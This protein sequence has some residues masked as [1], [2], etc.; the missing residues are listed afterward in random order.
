MP[1]CAAPVMSQAENE[2][3]LPVLER[4]KDEVADALGRFIDAAPGVDAALI[5]QLERDLDAAVERLHRSLPITVNLYSPI[6]RTPTEPLITEEQRDQRVAE[7][8]RML[9]Y[10]GCEV[11]IIRPGEPRVPQ[12]V[13]ELRQSAGPHFAPDRQL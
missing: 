11:V 3:E 5:V 4:L 10:L 9:A 7:L 8:R 2:R 12:L 13:G 6:T 1:F